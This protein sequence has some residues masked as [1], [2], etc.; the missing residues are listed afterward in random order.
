MF[1]IFA[2]HQGGGDFTNILDLIGG[3]LTEEQVEKLLSIANSE[4]RNVE[5]N[6][7]GTFETFIGRTYTVSTENEDIR[8]VD[9]NDKPL[10][11]VMAAGQVGF[12]ANTTTCKVS[13]TDCIVTEVFKGAATLM[14]SGG[15]LDF[16]LSDEYIAAEF[17]EGKNSQTYMKIPLVT[18]TGQTVEYMTRQDWVTIKAWMLEGLGTGSYRPFFYISLDGTATNW[19]WGIGTTRKNTVYT[20]GVHTIKMYYGTSSGYL[21]FDGERTEGF[22][23]DSNDGGAIKEYFPLWTT[24]GNYG[25]SVARKYYVILKVDGT[26]VLDL[27]PALDVNGTPCFFNKVDKTAIFNNGSDSFI[28]GFTVRQARKLNKLPSSGGVLTVSLPSSIVSG[29]T[30]TDSAVDAAL[31]TARAKGWNI[32]VQTYEEETAS[33]S[34]T[35]G[36]RRIWVRQMQDANGSYV[37]AD[38]NRWQVDWCVTMYTPD[39]STP[40]DHGYEQFRSIEAAVDYWGLTPYIDPTLEKPTEN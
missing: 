25:N 16:S 26:D 7:D 12:V 27:V 20:S 33:A 3:K 31:S 21:V 40:E 28:V 23:V 36:F 4:G 10:A 38:G 34:S 14:L 24:N 13:N 18:T 15:G 11:E 39:N 22:V 2:L 29:D 30:L 6:P 32:T 1:L 5:I 8:V 19:I 9:A 37:D 35:F 17:L